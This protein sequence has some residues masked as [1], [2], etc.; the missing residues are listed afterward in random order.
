MIKSVSIWKLKQGKTPEEFENW[1]EN[2]HVPDVRVA[3]AGRRY[4]TSKVLPGSPGAALG[5]Y[6]MAE[7]YFDS[8]EEMTRIMG[9]PE[10][11]ANVAD[12]G[13]WTA[14]AIRFAVDPTEQKT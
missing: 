7:F 4:V 11:A 10:W 6:R 3:M 8:V 13:D 14:D 9:S 2:K 5:Y 1:Y 12:A